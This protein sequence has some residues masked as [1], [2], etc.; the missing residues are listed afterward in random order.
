MP[1]GLAAGKGKGGGSKR[2]GGSSAQDASGPALACGLKF[3]TPVPLAAAV[4]GKGGTTIASIRADCKA[5]LSLTEHGEFFPNTDCR[6]LTAQANDEEHLGLVIKRI[7]AIAVEVVKAGRDSQCVGTEEELRLRLLIP[8]NA[9][10]G[11]IGKGGSKVNEIRERTDATISIHDPCADGPEAD[12]LVGVAGS[13][14]AL[15]LVLLEVS[16]QVQALSAEP[17]F[18][19]WLSANAALGGSRAFSTGGPLRSSSVDALIRVAY[20]LPPYV[21]EDARGFALNCVVPQRL[22]G[23]L[24]GRSGSGIKEVQAMTGT[25][26]GIRDIGD[27]PDN[28]SMNIAGPLASACAAYM[29]MMRRY[30]DAEQQAM[31][32]W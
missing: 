8:H 18:P 28:C 13:A 26:I 10:G 29:L 24:I 2:Y 30:L 21:M 12:Q 1:K 25:R 17:W 22:V 6:I 20:S 3:L 27:D 9:A 11:I 23:G 14:E 4:I 31:E 19:A 7:V 32:G 16:G 5:R 15:V